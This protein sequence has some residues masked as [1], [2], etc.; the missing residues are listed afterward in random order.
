MK[1][2]KQQI[3][4]K[5]GEGSVTLV[6][7]EP[8]DMW[9]LYNLVMRGDELRAS[10]YRKV[11]STSS[12]GSTR[13]DKKKIT[14]TL[15]V[16]ATS[17]DPVEGVI[18][19]KG[20]NVGENR[21]VKVGAY[22]TLELEAGRSFTLG[23]A[24]WDTIYMERLKMACDVSRKADLAAV[25]LQPG[26]AHVCLITSHMTVVR[27]KI[28]K[29]IPRKRQG[30][31]GHDK[32]VGSFYGSVMRAI[33][34]HVNFDIVKCVLVASP[35]FFKQDFLRYVRENAI[36]QDFR[37]LNA[38]LSRFVLC[39]AASGH[40]HD[41]KN[42]LADED[43]Q[44]QVQDTQAADEVRVLREFFRVLNDDPNR[45]FYG[46]KH[47]VMA[48]EAKAIDSLLVTDS[49]FRAADVKTR[50]EYVNLVESVR[51]NGGQV[52]V[53]S[54][55]HV[56]GEQLAL[57]TGVAAIL[58]FP[59]PDI[60]LANGGL[61]DESSSSSSSSSSSGES[62]GEDDDAAAAAGEAFLRRGAASETGAAGGGADRAAEDAVDDLFSF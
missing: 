59:M 36:K 46:F 17:F 42:V 26:L 40:K 18:R 15:R 19:V 31:S 32:A 21:W 56:S 5:D 7:E 57:V 14:L 39:H 20:V 43:V 62:A 1:I 37:E 51:E 44:R 41:L 10:T 35:G 22:H 61:F 30:R 33:V 54:S 48:D 29:S 58:R 12:T 52:Y 13:S 45:A 2:R 27:A 24:C 23:K 55:L 11:V 9:H 6:A 16:E 38:N 34:H 50:R 28:E 8:E 4:S 3:S 60:E 47:C 49:L 25:I 53:F